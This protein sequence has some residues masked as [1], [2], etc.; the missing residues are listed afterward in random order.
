MFVNE[1]IFYSQKIFIILT[2]TPGAPGTNNDENMLD[3][4]GL[5]H[6]DGSS[7]T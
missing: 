1:N 6:G 5:R 4:S 3:C 7:V 2:A